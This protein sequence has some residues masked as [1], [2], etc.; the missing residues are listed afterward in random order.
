MYPVMTGLSL[1]RF[2]DKK[3]VYFWNANEA[4]AK[5]KES[6]SLKAMAE[7]CQQ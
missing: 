6:I 3:F 2:R 5:L 7:V 1:L 4:S